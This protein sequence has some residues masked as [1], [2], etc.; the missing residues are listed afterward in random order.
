MKPN[1]RKKTLMI[2]TKS[3]TESGRKDFSTIANPVTPAAEKFI[4]MIIIPIAIAVNAVPT[5]N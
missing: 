1:R 2:S 4:G 5:I 3:E